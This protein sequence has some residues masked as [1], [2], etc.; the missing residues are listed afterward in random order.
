MAADILQ[1]LLTRRSVKPMLMGAP[2]PTPDQLDA[3]LTAAARVPDHK[4]LTP[5]RFI[6]FEGAARA[7][8]GEALAAACLAEERET[9]SAMRLDTER[10]RFLDAPVVIGVIS[11]T[12]ETA[13]APE[14]EQILSA[15][16]ACFNVCLAANAQGFASN[17]L[18]GWYA[19]SPAIRAHLKLSANERIAGYI[20]LGT[21]KEAPA[22]RERPALTT[23]VTRYKG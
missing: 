19:Y 7:T 20:H 5:W 8:F 13:G 22:D 15:G 3:I 17:W 6:V 9:P 18:T 16:A 12:T 21:A 23:I 4:K 14:W 1:F 2:G 11:R 10:R